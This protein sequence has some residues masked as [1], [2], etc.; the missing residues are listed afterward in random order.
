MI[1][2]ST[3]NEYEKW[4]VIFNG[5]QSVLLVVQILVTMGVPF[6]IIWL[7]NRRRKNKRKDNV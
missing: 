1:D 6:I 3:M 2:F 7:E 4:R 5:A